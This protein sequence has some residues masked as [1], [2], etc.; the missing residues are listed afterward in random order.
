[1]KN[2][3][4]QILH[5]YIFCS[6][7]G[8]DYLEA[9]KN[10]GVKSVISI[11]QQYQFTESRSTARS[12]ARLLKAIESGGV[13]CARGVTEPSHEYTQTFLQS[14]KPNDMSASS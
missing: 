11:F 3:D 7:L 13:Q 10:I 12:R 8:T 1:V 6:L 5:I 2:A 14:I 9:S 4:L